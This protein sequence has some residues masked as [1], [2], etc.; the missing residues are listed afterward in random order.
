VLGG[1]GQPSEFPQQVTA[2]AA[3][4]AQILW[5]AIIAVVGSEDTVAVGV[6]IGL[7]ARRQTHQKYPQY[8][9]SHHDLFGNVQPDSTCDEHMLVTTWYRVPRLW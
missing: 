3:D 8:A 7:Q 9:S 6:F 1:T 2:P 4:T 5:V